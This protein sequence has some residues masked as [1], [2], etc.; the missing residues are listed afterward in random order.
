MIRKRVI[1]FVF[2]KLEVAQVSFEVASGPCEFV[3]KTLPPPVIIVASQ[4]GS[5]TTQISSGRSFHV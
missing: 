2:V 4:A 1:L 5:G 3:A